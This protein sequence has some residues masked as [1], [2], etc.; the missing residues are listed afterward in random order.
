MTQ[1]PTK[2]Y[3]SRLSGRG[4]L[5]L[6]ALA[7]SAAPMALAEPEPTPIQTA[8][9]PTPKPVY[10]GP[11]VRIEP[12]KPPPV[13]APTLTA[14]PEWLV[15]SWTGG[16]SDGGSMAW[17]LTFVI[18]SDTYTLRGYPPFD[19]KGKIALAAPPEPQPDGSIRL[20]VHRYD[21]ISNGSPMTGNTEIWTVN[22]DQQ[23]FVRAT[24]MLFKKEPT[25]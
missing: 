5:L 8:E 2:P 22:A 18:S 21:G 11:P 19:E 6:A 13:V 1:T 15:G 20:H 23:S 17:T 7:G 24:N 3:P 14:I 12:L 16:G 10:G 9:P 4:A 25:K